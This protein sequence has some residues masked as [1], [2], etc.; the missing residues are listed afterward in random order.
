MIMETVQ[1]AREHEQTRM[2]SEAS[3]QRKSSYFDGTSKKIVPQYGMK[4]SQEKRFVFSC[5]DAMCRHFMLM[6]LNYN[7]EVKAILL[8][9]RKNIK[10]RL[11]T[12]I[13]VGGKAQNLPKRN[14]RPLSWV[15]SVAGK[16]A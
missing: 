16:I 11:Q 15:A 5:L 6:P 3:K 12:G 9:K 14:Q 10:L 8:N 1:K 13:R 7:A 4:F 2:V